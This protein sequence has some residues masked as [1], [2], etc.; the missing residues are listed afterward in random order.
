MSGIDETPCA[1]PLCPALARENS[2]FCEAHRTAKKLPMASKDW[3]CIRCKRV[4]RAGDYVT[5][6]SEP[7]NLEHAVCPKREVAARRRNRGDVP[8]LKGVPRGTP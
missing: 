4:V 1:V 6:E 2:I 5:I 3:S 8:L 7:G